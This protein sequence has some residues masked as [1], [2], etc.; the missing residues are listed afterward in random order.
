MPSLFVPK[1]DGSWRMSI[2]METVEQSTISQNFFMPR[3]ED[4]LNYLSG[5][6]IFSK[7]DMRSGYHQIKIRRGNDWK[8]TSRTNEGLYKWLVM[9][10]GLVLVHS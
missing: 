6:V 1:K 4:I 8:T 9:P 5:A 10:F 7:L 3:L 2:N